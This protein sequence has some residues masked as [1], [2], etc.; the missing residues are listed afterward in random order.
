MSHIEP[1]HYDFLGDLSQFPEYCKEAFWVLYSYDK[2]D[3]LTHQAQ[4]EYVN[5]AVDMEE[6]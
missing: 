4:A 2:R 5:P 3:P 6:V 1:F